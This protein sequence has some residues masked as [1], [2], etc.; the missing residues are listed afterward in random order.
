MTQIT[1]TVLTSYGT[2]D[3]LGPDR[4]PSAATSHLDAAGGRPWDLWDAPADW[5]CQFLR[6]VETGLL[7]HDTDGYMVGWLDP[8][9]GSIDLFDAPL[10]E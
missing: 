6:H 3:L 7:Y 5:G 4:A 2:K 1:I 8:D 9:T 10:D